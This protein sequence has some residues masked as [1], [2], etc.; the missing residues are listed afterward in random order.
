MNNGP[1]LL[2]CAGAANGMSKSKTNICLG[3][4]FSFVVPWRKYSVY[5][6]SF[7]NDID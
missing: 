1:P 3:I 7:R 2:S 6:E 4:S 5:R